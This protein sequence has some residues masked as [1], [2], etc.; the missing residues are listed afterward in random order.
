[1]KF[2]RY[3]DGGSVHWGIV[4]DETIYPVTSLS[5]DEPPWEQF[6]N[7][8]HRESLQD[9][10]AYDRFESIPLD[11]VSLRPP[12]DQPSKI[13]NVGLNYHDHAEEQNEDPPERPLLFSKAPS[14]IVGP[15]DAIVLPAAV[16]QIDYEVELA[17][18]V[19]RTASHVSASE[20]HEYIA[21]YTV[22]NDVSARDAQF[23]DG[24]FFRGK[25]YD[26][27]APIGPVLVTDGIDPNAVDIG[28]DVNGE[29]K[30]RSN[31]SEFIFDIGD[32]FE[33][34]TDVMTLE[35]GDVVSTG[36][37]GGVGIFS[38]PPDLLQPGDTVE[39]HVEGIGTLENPVVSQRD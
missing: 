21:G 4:R 10:L 25:S 35:P 31:T 38:D 24:Q 2:A 16:D 27:F 19:G 23:S 28:L 13:V 1:M 26:T 11:E 5:G 37:P 6:C 34:I 9:A 39:C 17:A 3:Q 36:T 32:L 8:S 29:P 15:G 14:A 12:V 7:E 22:F 33:F 20:A 18:V 30:Q